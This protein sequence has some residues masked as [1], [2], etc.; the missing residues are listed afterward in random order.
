MVVGLLGCVAEE[1]PGGAHDAGRDL[2][3]PPID[4][5][6]RNLDDA[7][8]PPEGKIA[9]GPYGCPGSDVVATPQCIN[10]VWSCPILLI[11]LICPADA[12]APVDAGQPSG[13]AAAGCASAPP[14]LPCG[15]CGSD[16]ATSPV[17]A[18]GTWSCP[19]GLHDV[20]T[21]P[22]TIPKCI[23][24]QPAGCFCNPTTGVVTCAQDAAA[25]G[26]S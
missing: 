20:R 1:L 13:D 24:A 11:D 3:R 22:P 4:A 8:C 2:G 10:G 17:C 6:E 15:T 14:F 26:P 16:T 21:C 18:D 7:G 23:G 12:G 9:C 5:I 19:P 25:D